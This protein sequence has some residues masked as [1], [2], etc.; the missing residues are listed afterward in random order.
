MECLWHL[1]ICTCVPS[2][3][4]WLVPAVQ[5]SV[6]QLWKQYSYLG[7]C[8]CMC[9]SVLLGRSGLDMVSL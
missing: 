3:D 5:Q 6:F 7:V 2:N 4:D 9:V 8:M 1:S